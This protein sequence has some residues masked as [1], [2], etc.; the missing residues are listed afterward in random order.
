M[1]SG[2]GM[3]ARPVDEYAGAAAAG[4][5]AEAEGEVEVEAEGAEEEAATGGGTLGVPL[6]DAGAEGRLLLLS[7][8]LL[9]LPPR[10]GGR[11]WGCTSAALRSS[12]GDGMLGRALGRTEKG[13]CMG[14][15]RLAEEVRSTAGV[16]RSLAGERPW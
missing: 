7:L 5:E 15:G 14:R 9:V 4:G 16:G 10:I 2:G 3:A 13:I 8:A 6:R 11:S 12:T 1:S